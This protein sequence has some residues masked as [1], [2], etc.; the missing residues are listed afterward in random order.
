VDFIRMIAARLNEQ[1][2][3]GSW[4][5]PLKH[6]RGRQAAIVDALHMHPWYGRAQTSFR[7]A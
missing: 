4:V 5:K 2:G 6:E 1:C 7:R 3:D